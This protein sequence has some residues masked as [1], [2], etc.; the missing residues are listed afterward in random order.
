MAFVRIYTGADGKSR[1]EDIK[2]PFQPTDPAAPGFVDLN[3]EGVAFRR[4]PVGL[5]QDWHTAPRRQYV[6]SLT[7][8]AELEAGNGEV[9]RFGPADVLLAEDLTGGGHVTRVVGTE[10]RISVTIPVSD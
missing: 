5:V 1:F 7:G 8:M 10:P 3:V 6:I 2:I 9:R 4:Q